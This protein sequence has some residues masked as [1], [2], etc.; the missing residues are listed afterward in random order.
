MF[1]QPILLLEFNSS[2][3]GGHISHV[4]EWFSK[5]YEC[6]SG[7]G[8]EC[9][10]YLAGVDAY[11]D[12]NSIEATTQLSSVTKSPSSTKHL[13]KSP[14]TIRMK[15]S[16]PLKSLLSHVYSTPN[17][18]LPSSIDSEAI[19]IP[20]IAN[21]KSKKEFS[22]TQNSKDYARGSLPARTELQPKAKNSSAPISIRQTNRNER[23]IRNSGS[24]ETFSWFHSLE[25]SYN[26]QSTHLISNELPSSSFKG[27][28]FGEKK[29][30]KSFY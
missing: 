8:C 25:G 1:P 4:Q 13:Q 22:L 23:M 10:T 7:C 9:S 5:N 3:H 2:G 26:S 24:S 20:R 6:P 29:D 11:D 27:K 30:S 21:S 15:N 19:G 16:P 12:I 28:S 17:L 14:P 18:Q